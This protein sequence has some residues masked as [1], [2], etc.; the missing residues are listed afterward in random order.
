MSKKNRVKRYSKIYR[1]SGRKKGMAFHVF[2]CFI[3]F[4]VVAA[5]VYLVA[6]G[7]NS[8]VNRERCVEIEI[9]ESSYERAEPDLREPDPEYVPPKK[10]DKIVAVE[11]LADKLSNAK[12]VTDFINKSK[13]EGKNAIVVSLKDENGILLY[14]SQIPQAREWGAIS[15]SAVDARKIAAEIEAAGL[16]PI[17]K[18]NAFYDQ[19]APHFKRNNSYVYSSQKVTYLFT[20]PVTKRSERWL[21]PYESSARKYICDIVAE[22]SELGYRQVFL[23]HVSFPA[24]ELNSKVNLGSDAKSKSEILRQFLDELNSKNV[25]YILAYD[26]RVFVEGNV[27]D[28]LYGGDI[29][30]YGAQNQAPLIDLNNKLN[31]TGGGGD[32]IKKFVDCVKNI[33]SDVSI[34]PA[35]VNSANNSKI[36]SELESLGVY[37]SFILNK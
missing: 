22:V 35:V 11:L 36:L 32:P 5:V 18:V 1:G 4:F 7:I 9:A 23:N 16:I 17:A 21:N 34:F 13:S 24:V 15:R 14:P 27:A 20:N 31:F 25:S 29:S 3:L 6:M 28:I 8:Y 30:T 33:G 26:W 37:S 19:T 2:V 12:Y 10:V